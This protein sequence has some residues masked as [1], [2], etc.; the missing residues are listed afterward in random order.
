MHTLA[1]GG[2]G[3]RSVTRFKNIFITF[4]NEIINEFIYSIK[5]IL[6]SNHSPTDIDCHL[7]NLVQ[8]HKNWMMFKFSMISK[9][10]CIDIIIKYVFF[11]YNN[12]LFSVG[13]SCSNNFFGSLISTYHISFFIQER[14][15][16]RWNKNH[17]TEKYRILLQYY[18]HTS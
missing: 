9:L 6:K 2:G 11:P 18:K 16:S 4:S 10:W 5:I 1:Y 14:V 17:H 8:Y 7:F 15:G 3:L 13:T 12:C